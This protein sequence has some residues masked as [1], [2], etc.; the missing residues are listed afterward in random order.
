MFFQSYSETCFNS[1]N[2]RCDHVRNLRRGVKHRQWNQGD[3]DRAINA[4]R[5]YR[6]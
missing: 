3:M 4:C 5:L 2:V 1:L 6:H